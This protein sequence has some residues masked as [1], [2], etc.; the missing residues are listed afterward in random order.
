[1][2]L[3]FKNKLVG[4]I[5]IPLV[6]SDFYPSCKHCLVPVRIYVCIYLFCVKSHF[7]SGNFSVPWMTLVYHLTSLSPSVI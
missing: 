7:A 4:L 5:L 6:N 1:L 2:P 3:A